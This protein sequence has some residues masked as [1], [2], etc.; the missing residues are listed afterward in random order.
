MSREPASFKLDSIA[1][2]PELQAG[3]GQL[4]VALEAKE[5]PSRDQ[6]FPWKLWA[7]RLLTPVLLLAALLGGHQ[8][9]SWQAKRE[10]LKVIDRLRQQGEIV[11]LAQR[12]A[13]PVPD[14]SNGA[15]DLRAAAAEASLPD[16][17]TWQII[18][19]GAP[20]SFPMTQR[21]IELIRPVVAANKQVHVHIAAAMNK[22]A[23]EWTPVLQ[24]RGPVPTWG[25]RGSGWFRQRSLSQFLYA[26]AL[27]AHHDGDDRTAV[28]R[29][30]ELL[31]MARI[32]AGR[33]TISSQHGSFGIHE[34][35]FRALNEILPKLSMGN[36]P[37]D[38]SP[39]QVRELLARVQNEKEMLDAL[40]SCLRSERARYIDIILLGPHEARAVAGPNVFLWGSEPL[41]MPWTYSDVERWIT[42]PVQF[43]RAQEAIERLNVGID[44]FRSPSLRDFLDASD[45]TA[46]DDDE[47]DEPVTDNKSLAP[48]ANALERLARDYFASLARRR[49]TTVALAAAIYHAETGNWPKAQLTELTPDYLAQIPI[50]PLSTTGERIVYVADS[51]RPRV[52]T[53]GDDGIDDGG[54]PAEFSPAPQDSAVM[55]DWVVDLVRQ[56]RPPAPT[57]RPN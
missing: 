31:F 54:W 47:S 13:V 15:F 9:W 5:P 51:D 45:A 14:A 23:I 36:A 1:R 49:C 26:S 27:L 32:N 24:A 40:L 28:T 10:F 19:G 2:L 4:A 16:G 8:L 7:L 34:Y 12:R 53:V 18:F 52:Y 3:P 6:P 57:T 25:G 11:S 46:H 29:I 33:P 17:D 37:R 20:L 42:R 50:D 30:G 44:S 43:G 56:P 39:A 21:E 55:A 48:L 35:A 22:P 38:A 41:P